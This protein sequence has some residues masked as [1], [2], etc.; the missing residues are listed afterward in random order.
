[1]RYVGF[2]LVAGDDVVRDKNSACGAL[3]GPCVFVVV[4]ARVNVLVVSR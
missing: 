1:M 3:Y 2:G 4:G